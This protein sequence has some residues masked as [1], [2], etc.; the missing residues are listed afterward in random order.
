MTLRRIQVE[1]DAEG[2]EGR[3]LE[4]FDRAM[5]HRHRLLPSEEDFRYLH[6]GRV[7]L[8]LADDL[9]DRQAGVLSR[10]ALAETR[11]LELRA[12]GAPDLPLPSWGG[13]SKKADEPRLA[14]DELLEA[15][16]NAPPDIQRVSLAEALDQV[17]HAHLWSDP[18]DQACA[19]SV[20]EAV[21]LPLAARVHPVL[22]RRFGWWVRR[23]GG[24]LGR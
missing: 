9:G 11:N 20:A 16:L 24:R 10:G 15:L 4:S 14:D 1:P 6:P 7:V 21:L 8:I 13:G 18:R 23:V 17:R 22:E 5:D 19:A 2:G 12:A 3:V